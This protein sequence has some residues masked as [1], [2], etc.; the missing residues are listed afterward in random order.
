MQIRCRLA[1]TQNEP[2]W[3][4]VYENNS[5]ISGRLV[6]IPVAE[7]PYQEATRTEPA[8]STTKVKAVREVQGPGRVKSAMPNGED[9]ATGSSSRPPASGVACRDEGE[10]LRQT[11]L[12]AERPSAAHTSAVRALDVRQ[13]LM[14]LDA[15]ALR[16]A[17]SDVTVTLFGET[18]TGK[19]RLARTLHAMSRRSAQPFVVFDCGAVVANLAE[20]ELFGH[21]KGSFT[22]AVTSHAGA[23]ERAHGGTL[24]LDEIGELPREI[25]PRLLRVLETRTVRRVGASGT[26]NTD[27]RVISATNRDLAKEVAEGRFRADLYY[28]LATATLEVAP[29]RARLHELPRLVDSLLSDLGYAN[30]SVSPAALEIL[31]RRAWLGN[32]RELKNVLSCSAAFVDQETLEPEHL[33][34]ALNTS[35]QPILDRLDLGGINLHDLEREAIAQTLVQTGGNKVRA[36]E[37]LGIAISTLYEK[38]KKYKIS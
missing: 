6:S 32:I 16:L 2:I 1:A 12:R 23:F 10:T 25:Q 18:G 17:R 37:R 5:S 8:S 20:S 29:L 15:T 9:R 11:S 30:V 24:F 36:A 13:D 21:E 19:D 28:R 27:I 4:H 34:F 35:E 26:K 33:T 31:R 38:L 3:G 22:G 7:V 14:E